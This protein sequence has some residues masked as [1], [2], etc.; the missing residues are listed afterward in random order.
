[1]RLLG[2]RS[3]VAIS[4]GLPLIIVALVI[5]VWWEP[6]S[7]SSVSHNH[8]SNPIHTHWHTHDLGIE[9]GHSHPGNPRIAHA[10]QH[11][12][13]HVHVSSLQPRFGGQLIQVGHSHE[14]AG[15]RTYWAEFVAFPDSVELHF[16]IDVAGTV[17]EWQS[18]AALPANVLV[19]RRLH[20]QIEFRPVSTGYR[21]ELPR[22]IPATAGV[23]VTLQD[24]PIEERP[25]DFALLVR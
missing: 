1:M 13:G 14:H 4:L 24:V 25:Y 21:V 2:N 18:S 16:L 7:R 3:F 12:H 19:D 9:H 10:H 5:A 20:A 22:D 6:P 15:T 17:T 8:G 11:E 23:V